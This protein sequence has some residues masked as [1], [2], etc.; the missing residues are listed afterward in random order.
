VE[1]PT[2]LHAVQRDVGVVEIEHDLARRAL[3]R[4]EEK[5]DQQLIDLCLV[6]ID[7][8]VLRAMTLRRVLNTIERAL[9]CQ[10]LAV[11]AQH[12]SQLP[13]Q[14]REN[15]ILT[16]LV[17]VVEVFIAQHQ[18]EDPLPHHRLDPMLDIARVTPVA[19]AAGKPTNQPQA[20]IHLAQQQTTRVRGDVATPGLRRG[21]LSKPA[22]T[23]RRS[24]TSNSNSFVVHSVCIGDPRRIW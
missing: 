19:E 2:L 7:L 8:V 3:M 20:A 15:W 13:G 23:A 5:I 9:A 22:T 21:R 4:L 6:G 11:R 16:Q 18:A 17:V 1:E 14:R 10:S 12:R 24:T